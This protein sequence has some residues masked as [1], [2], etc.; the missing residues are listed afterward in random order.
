MAIHYPIAN[1]NETIN[2]SVVT[3]INTLHLATPD[4]THSQKP[5]RLVI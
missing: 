1:L 3:S 4:A 5:P 2:L